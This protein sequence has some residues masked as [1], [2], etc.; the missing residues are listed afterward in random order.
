MASKGATASCA[1]NDTTVSPHTHFSNDG[2][3]STSIDNT[4][5]RSV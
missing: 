5:N 1:E 3:M 2:A 4:I